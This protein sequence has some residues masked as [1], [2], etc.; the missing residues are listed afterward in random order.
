VAEKLLYATVMA[1]IYASVGIRRI[2]AP[3][4]AGI[5]ASVGICRGRAPTTVHI[6]TYVPI[7]T[8]IYPSL[9]TQE[10]VE[11]CERSLGRE[12]YETIPVLYAYI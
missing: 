8:H 1:H 2:R 9:V 4:L 11:C 12:A 3:V 7:N 6:Y 10:P 5:Y